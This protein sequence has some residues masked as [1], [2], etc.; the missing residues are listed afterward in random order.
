MSWRTRAAALVLLLTW[1]TSSRAAFEFG[2]G[3]ARSLALGGAVAA[4]V[5]EPGAVWYNPAA[6]ARSAS[7]TAGLAHAQL[8]PGLGEGVSLS[9]LSTV[10]PVA[11]GSLQLAASYLGAEDWQE[12]VFV[13]GYGW[14]VTSRMGVGASLHSSGWE[15]TGLSHRSW[16]VDLGGTCDVGRLPPG[17]HLRL[18]LVLGNLARPRLAA[19]NLAG[20]RTSRRYALG[21]SLDTGGRMVVADV[22][23]VDGAVEL[24]AGCET[25]VADFGGAVMR[26]GGRAVSSQWRSA[27]VDVG[28]GHRWREWQLDYAYTYPLALSR[29][30]G[31]HWVTFG[32]RSRLPA[33][34]GR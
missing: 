7:P 24:S 10:V 9:A 33:V 18:A 25:R 11:R 12:S 22:A 34:R 14:A 5:G 32:Y 23:H 13:G 8:Y 31:I 21:A 29:F 19:G 4:V 16:S 3:G 17:G 20:G 26:F 1:A 6:N 2:G 28:L 15:T 30:G 27:E